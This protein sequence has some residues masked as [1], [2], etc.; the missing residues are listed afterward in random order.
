MGTQSPAPS[1]SVRRKSYTKR[2]SLSYQYK[3][4]RMAMLL[5]A[6]SAAAH[7]FSCYQK[8]SVQQGGQH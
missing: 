6:I 3:D 8:P 1:L 5:R 2:F 7:K 4:V